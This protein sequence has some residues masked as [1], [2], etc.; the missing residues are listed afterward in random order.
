MITFNDMDEFSDDEIKYIK[1]SSP[2][3][4]QQS[5]I[6]KLE[7]ERLR[8]E[9]ENFN[10]SFFK[11]NILILNAKNNFYNV[12]KL[13]LFDYCLEYEGENY[14]L[15]KQKNKYKCKRID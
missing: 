6:P 4:H 11:P 1:K 2:I 13:N 8:N 15:Y 7:L 12:E 10:S 3:L 5:I 9:F 14:L